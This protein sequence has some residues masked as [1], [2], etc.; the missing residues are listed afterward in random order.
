MGSDT[1]KHVQIKDAEMPAQV[2][3]SLPR[4]RRIGFE[5]VPQEKPFT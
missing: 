2:F 5:E 1:R 4:T 3:A